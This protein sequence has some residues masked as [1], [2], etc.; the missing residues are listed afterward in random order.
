M[1]RGVV[2]RIRRA[3]LPW[4]SSP[5]SPPPP[6]PR[7]LVLVGGGV[8]GGMYEVGVLAALEDAVPGFHA[9]RFDTYVGSSAGSVVAGL[10]AGGVPPRELYAILDEGRD[11]PLN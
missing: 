1:L 7:A 6:A 11:D 3:R 2:E 8:I 10:M 5:L 4:R 9:N